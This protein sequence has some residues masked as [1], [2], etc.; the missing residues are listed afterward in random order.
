MLFEKYL[1]RAACWVNCCNLVCL[2]HRAIFIICLKKS[3]F[4]ANRITFRKFLESLKMYCSKSVLLKKWELREVVERCPQTFF[5]NSHYFQK[6][7]L[8]HLTTYH[9]KPCISQFCDIERHNFAKILADK[10]TRLSTGSK[11]WSIE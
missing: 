8:I 10:A 7:D 4:N 5:H 6:C 11:D 1:N 2:S 3:F 9:W